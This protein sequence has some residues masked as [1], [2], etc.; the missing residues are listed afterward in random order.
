M[1][2]HWYYVYAR[3][4]NLNLG[5]FH[6]NLIYFVEIIL[7]FNSKINE[8]KRSRGFALSH[9]VISRL[10]LIALEMNLSSVVY[11]QNHDLSF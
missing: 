9:L 2:S 11:D 8:T 7:K 3:L 6:F 5:V 4:L 10:L 1:R